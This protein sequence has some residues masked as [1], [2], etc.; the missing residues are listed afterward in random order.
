MAFFGV[1]LG[2]ENV[3]FTDDAGE[4]LRILAG[5]KGN[6]RLRGGEIIAVDKIEALVLRNVGK[7][8]MS[9]GL[10]NIVPA[11]VGNF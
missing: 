10:A 11:H 7:Q 5:G 4:F 1:K 2:G 9:L 6:F 8:G 3:V